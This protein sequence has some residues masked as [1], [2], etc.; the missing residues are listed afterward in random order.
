[1]Y[2]SQAADK[3]TYLVNNN[4]LVVQASNKSVLVFVVF[5]AFGK[6]LHYASLPGDEFFFR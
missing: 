5:A 2:L 3:I 4:A 6:H 1:M